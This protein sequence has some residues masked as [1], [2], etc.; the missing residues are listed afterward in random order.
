MWEGLLILEFRAF[1]D[2]K[3]F[4]IVFWTVFGR[5]WDAFERQKPILN[6]KMVQKGLLQSDPKNDVE[7]C[8]PVVPDFPNFWASS[9][10]GFWGHFRAKNVT[11]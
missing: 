11:K 1:Q 2:E 10:G 6:R 9:L 8:L 7:N 4:L 5:F 3:R